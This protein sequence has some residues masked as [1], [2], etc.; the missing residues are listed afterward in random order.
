[1]DHSYRQFIHDNQSSSVG[2]VVRGV[3]VREIRTMGNDQHFLMYPIRPSPR[4]P[5]QLNKK[6]SWRG[7]RAD[8]PQRKQQFTIDRQLAAAAAADLQIQETTTTDRS[9]TE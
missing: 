1:M 4:P 9:C 6:G 8:Q 5:E 3:V 7:S 2:G